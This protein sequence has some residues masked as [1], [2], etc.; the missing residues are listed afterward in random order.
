MGTLL[1]LA[2][3]AN[4]PELGTVKW[5]R[6]FEVAVRRS[7]ETHK[8]MLVL[9]DE[10]PGCST[11]LGFGQDVLSDAKV[12]ARIERD[13]VPVA[14]FNNVKGADAKV[15]ASFDEPSWNNPV[16]RV[17]NAERT[18]LAPRFD[19]PYTRAAFMAVLDAVKLPA[20]PKLEQV[21]V[22]AACFWECEAKLGGLEAV[23]ASRV[24]FLDGAEVVEVQFDPQVTSRATFLEEAKRLDCANRIYTPNET[25]AFRA[26]EKDTKYF[27]KHSARSMSGLS[28]QDLVR[29]NA[30]AR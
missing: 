28:E 2:L 10:V 19:G 8:P 27:L 11:V 23:R 3:A 17:M 7:R 25:Q 30:A 1:L 29:A 6:D 9:F 22:S 24:G 15:L 4:P 5:E 13:F 26:S 20:A 12:V 16:V 21:T 18:P 14:V